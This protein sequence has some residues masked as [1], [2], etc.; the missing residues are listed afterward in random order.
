MSTLKH[1]LVCCV[2][3]LSSCLLTA[4]QPPVFPSRRPGP[5]TPARAK[6]PLPDGYKNYLFGKDRLEILALVRKDPQL[7]A[8]DADFIEGFEQEDRAVLVTEGKPWIPNVFFL[9]H[10]KKLFA[11]VIAFNRKKY[12]YPL[13][14]RTLTAKYGR[15][16]VL[17]QDMTVWQNQKT[18]LQLE[19][20][21]RLKYL[22]LKRFTEM[23]KKF[24]PELLKKQ[25]N[26]LT[27]LKGL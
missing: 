22:D 10:E 6:L 24:N 1:Y 19:S 23:K 26:K 4:A 13:L 7:I 9:F 14:I 2:A 3:F 20:S 8:R 21:L 15:A 18:R 5:P 17:G 16:K 11:V 27:T 25:L 12:S